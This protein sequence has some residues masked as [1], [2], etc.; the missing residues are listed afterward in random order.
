MNGRRFPNPWVVIPVVVG[1]IIGGLIGWSVVSVGCRP[2]TC[3]A[4]S[5]ATGFLAGLATAAGVLVVVVLAIRSL[6]EWQEASRTGDQ[7][8]GP[9]CEVPRND[10][11]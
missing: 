1:G 2:S 7:P 6:A 3:V 8:A 4:A 10:G 9:G 5:V 11:T